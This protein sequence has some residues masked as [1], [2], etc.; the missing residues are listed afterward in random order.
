M[1]IE[2]GMQGVA[3]GGGRGEQVQTEKEEVEKV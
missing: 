1:L 3:G 2:A